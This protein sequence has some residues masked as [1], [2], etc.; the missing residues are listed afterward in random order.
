MRK[1]ELAARR[2]LGITTHLTAGLVGG[3]AVAAKREGDSMRRS[4]GR[5]RTAERLRRR[6]VWANPCGPR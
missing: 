4:I 3:V 6:A 1:I 2:P 5:E